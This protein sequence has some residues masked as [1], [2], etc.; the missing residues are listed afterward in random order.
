MDTSQ[1]WQIYDFCSGSEI[2]K[3]R[4]S[5][6]TVVVDLGLDPVRKLSHNV[7]VSDSVFSSAATEQG[8]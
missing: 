4:G 5:D 3:S 8:K 6:V 7:D 2:G 1:W